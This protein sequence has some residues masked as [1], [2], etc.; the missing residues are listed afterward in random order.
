MFLSKNAIYFNKILARSG[1]IR[2]I[3]KNSHQ[4]VDRVDFLN[5]KN[6][7]STSIIINPNIDLFIFNELQTTFINSQKSSNGLISNV[8]YRI[9]RSS[10]VPDDRDISTDTLVTTDVIADLFSKKYSILELKNMVNDFISRIDDIFVIDNKIYK[11]FDYIYLD[12]ETLSI[13]YA[14]SEDY[15]NLFR[16]EQNLVVNMD[17]Y[18]KTTSPDFRSFLIL[19]NA[20][21]IENKETYLTK[22]TL[23]KLLQCEDF[24]GFNMIYKSINDKRS[25]LSMASSVCKKFAFINNSGRKVFYS[26]IK[27]TL[28]NSKKAANV[29][30][31]ILNNTKLSLIQKVQKINNIIDA[32]AK[33]GDVKKATG[34]KNILSDFI[35]KETKELLLN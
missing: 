17:D 2:K 22:A 14:L 35:S 30:D 21:G 31:K 13:N 29:I 19:I 8:N 6:T 10:F 23:K 26:M 12:E 9:A 3:R 20:V 34:I 15:I 4:I 24:S 25:K 32:I 27:F 28:N 16:T 7:V 18:K 11:F 1:I 33:N 5:R